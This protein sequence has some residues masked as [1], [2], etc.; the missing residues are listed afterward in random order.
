MDKKNQKVA[1]NIDEFME[2][3]EVILTFQDKN[4]LDDED[5]PDVLENIEMME[6][7]KA[8][9]SIKARDRIK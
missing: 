4:I 8:Q 5:G 1:H 6:K 2:N 9:I 7:D 3:R